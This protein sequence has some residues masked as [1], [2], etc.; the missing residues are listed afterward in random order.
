MKTNLNGLIRERSN[1]TPTGWNKTV[2]KECGGVGGRCVGG[3]S[4]GGD[5]SSGGGWGGRRVGSPQRQSRTITGQLGAGGDQQN[6]QRH[7]RRE[8][9]DAGRE[10]RA[11]ATR[12]QQVAPWMSRAPRAWQM[13]VSPVSAWSA[14]AGGGGRGGGR[15]GGGG[16]HNISAPRQANSTELTVGLNSGGRQPRSRTASRR[17]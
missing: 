7:I 12:K 2:N 10:E 1:A 5:V 17:L 13:G 4:G 14:A 9:G 16:G 3:T 6:Q 11:T 15:G 8:V